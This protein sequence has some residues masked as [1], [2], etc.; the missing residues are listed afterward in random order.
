MLEVTGS[1]SEIVY[2]P[3]RMDDPMQRKP[4]ITLA[5]EVLGWAPQIQLQEGLARTAGWFE[6]QLESG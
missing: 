6:K 5:G 3:R 1:T 2:L 4:D